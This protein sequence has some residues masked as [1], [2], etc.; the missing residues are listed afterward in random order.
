[1]CTERHRSRTDVRDDPL[2]VD[3]G[4]AIAGRAGPA[5][6]A[7]LRT[8]G[9]LPVGGSVLRPE[10]VCGAV[11]VL[12][13]HGGEDHERLRGGVLAAAVGVYRAGLDVLGL[14]RIPFLDT[15]A[16]RTVQKRY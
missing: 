11:H 4:I 6:A 14:H 1:D 16:F 8:T 13:V 10:P 3:R 7:W 9:G 12:S 2:R 15:L 5:A